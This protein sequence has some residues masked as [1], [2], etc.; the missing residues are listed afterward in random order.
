MNAVDAICH[1][2]G[3]DFIW[4]CGT[5]R[6]CKQCTKSMKEFDFRFNLK[7]PDYMNNKSS[8]HLEIQIERSNLD[9]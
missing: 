6:I 2:C 5:Q 9:E 3:G 8:G 1:V 4:L 7:K